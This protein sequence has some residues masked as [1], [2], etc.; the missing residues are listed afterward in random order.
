MCLN[1]AIFEDRVQELYRKTQNYESSRRSELLLAFGMGAFVLLAFVAIGGS[2]VQPACA[3]QVS[4]SMQ[5]CSPV[6]ICALPIQTEGG[7]AAA[8]EERTRA[9]LARRL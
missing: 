5:A 2:R 9:R 1:N 6:T 4:V 7:G 3:R 8:W